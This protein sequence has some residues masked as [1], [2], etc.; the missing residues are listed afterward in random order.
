MRLREFRA[1]SIQR[2]GMFARNFRKALVTEPALDENSLA[3]LGMFEYAPNFELVADQGPAVGIQP[4][5]LGGAC[6]STA[7]LTC[8][9]VRTGVHRVARA[10]TV[11]GSHRT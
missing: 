1:L 9:H 2:G 6:R 4:L 7:R 5:V 3:S 11:P 10:V 8:H